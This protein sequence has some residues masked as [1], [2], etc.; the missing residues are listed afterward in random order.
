LIQ[1]GNEVPPGLDGG[2]Q[3]TEI[4][5]A[6]IDKHIAMIRAA[7]AGGAQIVCLQ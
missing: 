3:F 2:A 4:K 5:Q 7:A 1:A 6:M